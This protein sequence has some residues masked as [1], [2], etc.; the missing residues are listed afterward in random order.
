M[1]V[2]LSQNPYRIIG[3]PSN[4]GIKLIKKNVSKLKAFSKIGKAI[5]FDF[6]L[7]SL[8]LAALDRSEDIISRVESKILLDENKIKYSLFWFQD[9]SAYDSVALK[10][11]FDGK[12]DK[13]IE[14][15]EKVTKSNKI[16]SKNIFAYNNLS[17]LLLFN[18]L[19][20]SKKDEFNNT[21]KSINELKKALNWKFNL[22]NSNFFSDFCKSCGSTKDISSITIKTFLAD[23][24]LEILNVNF[25]NKD[26]HL[27][28]EGLDESFSS[29]INVRL[30]KVPLSEIE[31][32]IKKAE[33]KAKA[34]PAK[35][36]IIGEELIKKSSSHIRYLKDILGLENFQYQSIA[37][38]LANKILDC[39]IC[40]WNE[41]KDIKYSKVFLKSYK[42]ALTIAN[43]GKTKNRVKE[44]IKH[45]QGTKDS[46]ICK[47]C[48][49]TEVSTSIRVKMYMMTGY[50]TYSYF[51][52]GGL[53]VNCCN[54][55]KNKKQTAKFIAPVV[56]LTSYGLI[57]LAT[58]GVS[59]GIDLLFGRFSI[60]KW[61]FRFIGK[62]IFY[63]SVSK[64]PQVSKVQ[65]EGYLYGTP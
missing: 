15:W 25:S 34:N 1:S 54:N 21:K 37:D 3:V 65:R 39:G 8:N 27:L 55:C 5:D 16:T 17:T 28:S 33:K 22:I 14:I 43:S 56:A 20:Y 53:E 11:L 2:Y 23:T 35:G 57:A 12:M 30:T 40:Y 18:Q 31:E 58:S 63:S 50:S 61:W 24:I 29:I 52:N 19:S 47:F 62:Q 26:L 42:Y 49:L 38:K 10:N 13:A 6:D 7:S 64:H 45:C 9:V 46:L 48:N 51:Q 41:T 32:N 59:I 36:M 4:S 60:G 44:C